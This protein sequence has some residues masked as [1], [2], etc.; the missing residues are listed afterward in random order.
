MVAKCRNLHQGEKA[1]DQELAQ[2]LM[3]VPHRAERVVSEQAITR[4]VELGRPQ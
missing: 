2:F 3:R 1:T 4:L